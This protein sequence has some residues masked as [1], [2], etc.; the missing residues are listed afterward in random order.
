[1]PIVSNFKTCAHG[2]RDWRECF[3]CIDEVATNL[4]IARTYLKELAE[5]VF[6]DNGDCSIPVTEP[7]RGQHF[8]R[9]AATALGVI[10]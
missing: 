4:V 5:G 1:M 8:Q 10:S 2:S 3:Q 7:I 6:N 9:I